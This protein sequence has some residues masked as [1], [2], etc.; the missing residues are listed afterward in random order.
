M[1]RTGSADLPLHG[2]KAPRWLFSRMEKLTGAISEVII[3]EYSQEELLRRF[4]DPY[5][6]QSLGCVVGFD[7]H[8]SGLTTTLTG[9]LKEA[10]DE[11]EHGV[12]VVGGKGS[13][14]RKAPEEILNSRIGSHSK[15]ERLAEVSKLSAKVDSNC[16]QDSY[17]LYHH[18]LVFTE[19]GKWA[20]I[21]QGM[22]P[23]NKYARRYHW[24]SEDMKGFVNEPHEGISAMEREEEVLNLTSPLS[25]ET[26]EVSVDLVKDG[27]EHLER[28]LKPKEQTSMFNFSESGC[29]TKKLGMPPHHDVRV[30][31]LT[32]QTLKNLKKAKQKQPEDYEELVSTEDVGEKSLRALAL[33]AQLVHGTENDWEDPAR[34]SFAHG[35]KDGY[36]RPVNR[37]QYD[38]SIEILEEALEKADVGKKEK[39]KSLKKLSEIKS[40]ED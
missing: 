17:N 22:N 23:G 12:K 13:T 8:S 4:S 28:Y 32:Q 2:G 7:W 9:A 29:E 15:L 1:Q 25:E 10:L 5:W 39:L 3:R 38:R 24:L 36:P 34:F 6:F 14:S 16:V 35:G 27:P 26:R 40:S 37:K 11:E 20:V 19:D 30:S 18:V 21:Q 31:E 33:I